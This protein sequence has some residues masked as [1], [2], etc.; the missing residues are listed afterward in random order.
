MFRAEAP[1]KSWQDPIP[2][3]KLQN[4]PMQS[5]ATGDLVPL[6]VGKCYNALFNKAELFK[7][8]GKIRMVMTVHDSILFD[9]HKDALD[10][11]VREIGA[12]LRDTPAY[13]K[14]VFNIDFPTHT[15]IGIAYGRTWML[16]QGELS[17]ESA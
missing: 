16:E 12:V 8:G 1:E 17:D 11:L 4:Y 15:N 13:L 10:D 3:T 5:G 7:H 2:P 14:S 9:V 6:M